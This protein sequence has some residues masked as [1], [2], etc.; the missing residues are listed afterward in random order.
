MILSVI[1]VMFWE[2]GLWSKHSRREFI[3]V[4]EPAQMHTSG[5]FVIESHTKFLIMT[6]THHGSETRLRPLWVSIAVMNYRDQK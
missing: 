3:D 2:V 4:R 1:T 5:K 6:S